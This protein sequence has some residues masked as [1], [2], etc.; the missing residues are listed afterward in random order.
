MGKA[1][2]FDELNGFVNQSKYE[3][4]CNNLKTELK[5][6]GLE[7]DNV[8]FEQ[9]FGT[10]MFDHIKNIYNTM[11]DGKKPAEELVNDMMKN[12]A[13][14]ADMKNIKIDGDTFFAA[15]NL[16]EEEEK[17][18]KDAWKEIRKEVGKRTWGAVKYVGR[19]TL[20]ESEAITKK[21]VGTVIRKSVIDVAEG[22][23]RNQV[24]KGQL[25]PMPGMGC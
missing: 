24:M 13:V 2:T 3:D 23:F 1:K 14:G 10:N 19:K 9:M 25:P 11:D 22:L 12:I 5:K 15:A 17:K 16:S 8:A 4:F 20:N 6:N 7:L 18:V 21:A